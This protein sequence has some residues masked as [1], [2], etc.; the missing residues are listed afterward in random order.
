MD[1]S[2]YIKIESKLSFYNDV[3]IRIFYKKFLKVYIINADQRTVG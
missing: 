2:S 3:W 1:L